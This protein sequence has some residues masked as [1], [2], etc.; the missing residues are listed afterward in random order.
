MISRPDAQDT[1]QRV[2]SFVTTNFYMADPAAL[3]D[4]ISLLNSGIIDSTGVLEV[5]QFLEQQFGI[6]VKDEELL[7]DNL[8]SVGKIVR[9]IERKQQA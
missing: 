4:E 7:P 3:G 6:H 5:I 8:D 2:R 1:N 9:F